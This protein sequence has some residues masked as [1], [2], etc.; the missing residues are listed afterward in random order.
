MLDPKLLRNDP[1]ALATGLKRLGMEASILEKLQQLDKDRR[2][3]IVDADELKARRNQTSKELADKKK[4]GEDISE[5]AAAMRAV[6]QQ[7][8]ELD[9][10]TAEYEAALDEGLQNIPNLPHESVPDGTDETHNVLVRSWGEPKEF[11][12]TPLPHWD[13]GENLDLIDFK[14]A[15]KI[16]GSRFWVLKGG[17]ARLERALIS[18]MLDVHTGQHG[19]SEIM[20]PALVTSK[21]LYGTGQLPKFA[22]DLFHCEGTDLY[23]IPTSEVS[24]TNLHAGEILEGEQL[25]IYYTGFSPCFRSEAGA[26]GRDTRGLIRVHQFH[27][28][29]MIKLVKPESS[30][31]E[32]E[33]MVGNAEKILQLL[34]I[35]Y[36]VI[37][38]C[39]GDKSFASAKTYD[40]EFW[41]PG[42]QRWVEISSCSNCTDFQARRAGIRYKE[43]PNSPTSFVHTLNGSGLAVGRTMV[44]ILEN[45]QQAD[46]SVMVPQALRSYLGGLEKFGP[47]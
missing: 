30:F 17:G 46:G 35:P 33:K 13:V 34:E 45:Y 37:A 29:E 18:F 11:D 4:A 15:S 25:P 20:T 10:K 19:Y 5:Q 27:K 31:E 14:R 2:Q 47:A 23:L 40:L 36:R 42:Q 3:T 44:A 21:T 43:N 22:E 41:S 12:F 6:S 16:S 24:I 26:A 7:I 1:E 28:V 9:Q 39:V 8:K 38:L 32:L